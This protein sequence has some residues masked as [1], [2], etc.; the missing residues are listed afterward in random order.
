MRTSATLSAK[1][2]FV[3]DGYVDGSVRAEAKDGA[4]H[5]PAGSCTDLHHH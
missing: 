3:G 4:A 5:A 2:V 1:H